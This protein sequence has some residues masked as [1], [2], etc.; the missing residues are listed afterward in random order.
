M[1]VAVMRPKLPGAAKVAPYLERIDASRTYS[2]FGPLNTALEQR[3]AAHYGTAERSVTA[4]SNATVGLALALTAQGVKPGALCIMPAWTFIASAHAAMMA[5]LTPYFVDVDPRTWQLDPAAMAEA[6]ARAPGEVAAVMPV[7]PFGRPVDARAWEA[8][9]DKTGIP[10]VIDAAAGFDAAMAS[11]IPTVVSLHATKALGIG[12]GGF[13][14]STD[15]ALITEI[16]MLSNFGFDATRRAQMFATNGKLSEY[17]AAVGLAALDEWDE[18]REEW[19]AAAGRYRTA[20]QTNQMSLQ[21]GF[22]DR[23]V[24]SACVLELSRPD[25]RRVEEALTAAGIETRRWWGDG[26]RSPPGHQR[27]DR[28]D[29]RRSLLPG[30]DAGDRR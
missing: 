3:L 15:L 30:P 27:P 6:I 4:V 2:N 1:L 17:H 7:A 18:T 16:R 8:F 25:A 12:E 20:L 9:R 5:G 10:V 28:R 24:G 26:A 29:P 23:W 13:V 11:S 22:G 14:L 19:K 21:P